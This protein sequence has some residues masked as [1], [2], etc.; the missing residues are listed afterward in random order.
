MVQPQL[1]PPDASAFGADASLP[2]TQPI[3]LPVV[4]ELDAAGHDAD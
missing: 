3:D 4:S 2:P 1:P